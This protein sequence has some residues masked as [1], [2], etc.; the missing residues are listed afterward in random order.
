MKICSITD[1]KI[2]TKLKEHYY[3]N[4][5]WVDSDYIPRNTFSNWLA[6]EYDAVYHFTKQSIVF[7]NPK[8]YTHFALLWL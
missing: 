1:P 2:L 4:I 3:D 8:K 5:H 7:K 6:T